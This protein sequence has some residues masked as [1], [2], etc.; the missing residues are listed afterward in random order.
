MDYLIINYRDA[1]TYAITKKDFLWFAIGVKKKS[2]SYKDVKNIGKVIT[3]M[4]WII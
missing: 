2:I 1:E 4:E 3:G